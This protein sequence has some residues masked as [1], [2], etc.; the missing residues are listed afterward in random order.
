[1]YGGV[2]LVVYDFGDLSAALRPMDARFGPHVRLEQIATSPSIVHA[3]DAVRIAFVWRSDAT[4]DQP[5]NLFVHLVDDTGKIITQYDG[6][7]AQR[8]ATEWLTGKSQL[9]RAAV[10]VPPGTSPGDYH[11]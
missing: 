10:L 4:P 7:S 9:G 1:W 2:E 11:L 8:P 3:G 5:L 6:P